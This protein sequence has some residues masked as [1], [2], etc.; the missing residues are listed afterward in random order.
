MSGTKNIEAFKVYLQIFK[1]IYNFY[2]FILYFPDLIT[3]PL[4]D[5]VLNSV[6]LLF[7]RVSLA[8]MV[9]TGDCIFSLPYL[10]YKSMTIF[11]SQLWKSQKSQDDFKVIPELEILGRFK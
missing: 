11:A 2:I 5:I 9:Y 1:Y 7:F 3:L 10:L 6:L 8:V 4:N